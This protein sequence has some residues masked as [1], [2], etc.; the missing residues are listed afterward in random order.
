MSERCI[1]GHAKKSHYSSMGLIGAGIRYYGRCRYCDCKSYN[2]Q[3]STPKVNVHGLGEGPT[4]DPEKPGEVSPKPTKYKCT[5][6]STPCAF[7]GD[8]E[9]VYDESCIH[10]IHGS[11]SMAREKE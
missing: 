6:S 5:L 3:S 4:E 9:C 11:A 7:F 2:P 10:K 8:G 1:C